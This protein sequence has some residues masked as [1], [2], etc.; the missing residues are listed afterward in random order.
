MHIPNRLKLFNVDWYCINRVRNYSGKVYAHRCRRVIQ[1]WCLRGDVYL[2]TTCYNMRILHTY[3]VLFS[4]S[5]HATRDAGHTNI[6]TQLC[7][8]YNSVYTWDVTSRD[9]FLYTVSLFGIGAYIYL[10]TLTGKVYAVR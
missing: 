2:L 1:V 5:C 8:S 10:C 7:I 9:M 6:P 4:V 3:T